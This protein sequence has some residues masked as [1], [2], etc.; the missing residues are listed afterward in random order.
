MYEATRRIRTDGKFT[1]R[2][3]LVDDVADLLDEN[4]RVGAVEASCEFTPAMLPALERAIEHPDMTEELA[5]ILST[6]VVEIEY[7]V[8]T[9]VSVQRVKSA[10]ARVWSLPLPSGFG[11]TTVPA[12]WAVLST[13][14][15]STETGATVAKRDLLQ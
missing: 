9:D 1:Y 6:R 7:E 10:G 5:E 13:G 2:A 15:C 11:L 4:T 14:T 8:S 3:N 12:R